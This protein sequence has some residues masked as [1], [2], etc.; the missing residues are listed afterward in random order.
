MESIAR[1]NRA[2]ELFALPFCPESPAYL[3]KT[4]GSSAAL[5]KLAEVRRVRLV[6]ALSDVGLAEELLVLPGN[7]LR[8]PARRTSKHPHSPSKTPGNILNTTQNVREHP[9]NQSFPGR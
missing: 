7:P 4:R 8:H 2:L 5:T 1:T 3:Y 9:K 6:G